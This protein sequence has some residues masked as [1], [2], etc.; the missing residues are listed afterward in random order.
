MFPPQPP[1][2]ETT[3]E[4]SD[5]AAASTRHL[6]VSRGEREI[7]L[8]RHRKALRMSPAKDKWRVS[9]FAR[10]SKQLHFTRRYPISYM[11]SCVAS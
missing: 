7:E 9:C 5:V 8:R 4:V 2:R 3:G 6:G 10:R 1:P 11:S